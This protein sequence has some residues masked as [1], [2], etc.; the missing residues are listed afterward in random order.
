MQLGLHLQSQRNA[1]LLHHHI[2]NYEWDNVHE[3]ISQQPDSVKCMLPNTNTPLHELCSIGSAPAALIKKVLDLWTGAAVTKNRHGETPLHIKCRNSQYSSSVVTFLI[4]SNPRALKVQNN[5]GKTPLAVAC[6]SGACFVVIRELVLA[7]PDALQCTD[8]HGHTTLDLLWSTFAKT[9]PGASAISRYL[10]KNNGYSNT[11]TEGREEQEEQEMGGLL[12]R[13]HEKIS[14]CLSHAYALSRDGDGGDG[15]FSS[16]LCHAIIAQNFKHC[17]HTLLAIFL[18]HDN[19]LGCQV[20]ENGKTPL[21]LLLTK[22][23]KI[24]NYE[25]CISR[26]L[27]KCEQSASI[28]N[29]ET[30]MLPLHVALEQLQLEQKGDGVGDENNSQRFSAHMIRKIAKAYP[31]ALETRDP[32]TLFYP[33]IAAAVGNN[34]SLTYEFLLLCPNLV[35]NF[36]P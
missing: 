24:W 18:T 30:A 8:V 27:E 26:V 32:R 7:N 11:R 14:L 25:K 35:L 2:S 20:D 19:S 4:S 6:G 13:F 22:E 34:L 15:D 17:P 23:G 33:F 21:H 5:T 9:L 36:I 1:F 31:E 3:V 16:L 28:P 29:R 12:G 10:T